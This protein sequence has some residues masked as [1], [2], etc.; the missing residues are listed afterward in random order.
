MKHLAAIVAATL[1][2]AS[3]QA[4]GVLAT[5][6]PVTW[7]MIFAFLFLML[8]PTKLLGPFAAAT[9][10]LR[11]F[12]ASPSVRETAVCLAIRR[13]RTGSA[14]RS[15]QRQFHTPVLR[16]APRRGVGGDRVRVAEP[17][18]GD[19]VRLHALRD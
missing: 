16:S 8:G 2:P 14:P 1:L 15:G 13:N 11:P 7:G 17:P 12:S 18:R 5:K 3:A 10:E 6:R 19:K 9:K 4:T